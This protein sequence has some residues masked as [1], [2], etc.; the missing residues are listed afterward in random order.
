MLLT[1]PLQRCYI[2]YATSTQLASIL[3]ATCPRWYLYQVSISNVFYVLPWAIVCQVAHLSAGD[4]WTY[5]SIVFVGSLVFT[6]FD[7]LIVDAIWA[8]KL[9][10]GRMR[11]EVFS[12]V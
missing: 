9:H 5:H 10:T 1:M 2:L 3:L 11:L 4:A 8:W 6:F 12:S 7:V